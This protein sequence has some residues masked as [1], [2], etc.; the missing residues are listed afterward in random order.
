MS[1]CP[2]QPACGVM[3]DHGAGCEEEPCDH[4]SSHGELRPGSEGEVDWFW[5][6]DE[7]DLTLEPQRP[8]M[9]ALHSP[10]AE[11]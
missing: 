6:C 1:A 3:F 2:H 11:V 4:R 10:E 9:V 8:E 5:V 7:C